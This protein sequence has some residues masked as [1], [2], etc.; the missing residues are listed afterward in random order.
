M[1]LIQSDEGL[2]RKRLT[3]LQEEAI[4]PA[5]RL[6]TWNAALPWVSSLT[7]YLVEFGL[8]Q[9]PHNCVNQFLKINPPPLIYVHIYCQ[10]EKKHF[11]YPFRC[12]SL[13]TQ[14][15]KDRLVR[16]RTVFIHAH[17]Q[18]FTEK[19]DWDQLELYVMLIGEKEQEKGAY[20]KTNGFLGLVGRQARRKTN[21]F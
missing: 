16:E 3:S 2:N 4:L 20:R 10:R 7:I 18:D 19:H 13:Q 9:P 15:K 6:W 17:I 5:N 21:D 1:G 8:A 14:L 11:L 12:G